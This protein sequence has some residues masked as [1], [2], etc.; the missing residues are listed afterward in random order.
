MTNT[1][2]YFYQN[3]L[4]YDSKVFD[5]L[6]FIASLPNLSQLVGAL[7]A[8]YAANKIGRKKALILFCLPLLSGWLMI[9]FSS[10]R[11]ILIMVGRLLKVFDY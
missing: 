10:G 6:K 2:I 8:G 1:R 3:S 5:D 11:S 9:I 7:A 4:S